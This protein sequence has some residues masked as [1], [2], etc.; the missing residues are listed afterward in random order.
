M[1]NSNG[2]WA[3]FYDTLI[4]M[5]ALSKFSEKQFSE[6]EVLQTPSRFIKYSNSSSF[7]DLSDFGKF[8]NASVFRENLGINPNTENDWFLKISV[9]Y[10]IS[11]SAKVETTLNQNKFKRSKKSISEHGCSHLINF[12]SSPIPYDEMKQPYFWVNISK[13]LDGSNQL[14]DLFVINIGLQPNQFVMR[15]YLNKIGNNLVKT[16]ESY[17]ITNK[18][19]IIF[20]K[21]QASIKF[22]VLLN[23]TKIYEPYTPLSI[24]PISKPELKC[25][26]FR[27][28]HGGSSKITRFCS[29]SEEETCFCS[30]SKSCPTFRDKKIFYK[31]DFKKFYSNS[32]YSFV[33]WVRTLGSPT[34]Q[35][36]TGFKKYR[37]KIITPYKK[38]ISNSKINLWINEHCVSP[39][40]RKSKYLVFGNALVNQNNGILLNNNSYIVHQ[41]KI[42]GCRKKEDSCLNTLNAFKKIAEKLQ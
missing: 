1:R 24:Y 31:K 41:N 12:V 40:K 25:S 29:E 8:K 16:I 2:K 38:Y 39:L 20:S 11:K 35:D 21:M 30:T 36:K 10:R 28:I 5:K 18:S 6:T 34:S 17:I 19:L 15:K 14:D 32:N 37:I 3:S 23:D 22:Q 7:L 42:K 13:P 9:E 26:T 33:Y 27:M 4:A